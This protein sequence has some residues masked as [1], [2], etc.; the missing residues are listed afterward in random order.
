M[1]KLWQ[2]YDKGM[3]K[4][5]QNGIKFEIKLSKSQRKIEQTLAKLR[6]TYD[7]AEL[8]P[9]IKIRVG[10]TSTLCPVCTQSF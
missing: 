8:K 3:K 5:I 2:R 7:N 10:V 9:L 6:Q 1:T 4:L